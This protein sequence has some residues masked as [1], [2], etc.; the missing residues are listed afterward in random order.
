MGTRSRT[1]PAERL[2]GSIWM[3][4]YVFPPDHLFFL[5]SFSRGHF[6]IFQVV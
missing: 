2:V 3:S 4:Y 6:I 1:K 5:F